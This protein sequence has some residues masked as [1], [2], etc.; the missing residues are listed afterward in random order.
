LVTRTPGRRDPFLRFAGASLGRGETS[1]PGVMLGQRYLPDYSAEGAKQ[2]VTPNA[3]VQ[4]R[5]RNPMKLGEAPQLRRSRFGQLQRLKLVGQRCRT[6]AAPSDLALAVVR[7]LSSARLTA[8]TSATVNDFGAAP[9]RRASSLPTLRP[10]PVARR[11]A[12][13]A[14]GLPATALARLDSHRLDSFERFQS[15]HG[16]PSPLPGLAWRDSLDYS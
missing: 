1:G 3:G 10:P 12:R 5:S 8:S 2:I 13:L 9:S 16:G 6:P 11:E 4:L 15:G 7:I 14:T